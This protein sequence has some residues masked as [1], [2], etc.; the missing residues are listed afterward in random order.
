ML[1]LKR[2]YHPVS[3]TDGTR[4]LVERLWPRGLS[5]PKLQLS[6]WLRDAGPR[7]AR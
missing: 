1:E 3:H 4:V 2:V 7:A 6:A 5:K